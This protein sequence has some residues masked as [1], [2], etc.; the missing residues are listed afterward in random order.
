[1]RFLQPPETTD[2]KDERARS[3]KRSGKQVA[4]PV[5]FPGAPDLRNPAMGNSGAP[6]IRSAM[7]TMP[8]ERLTFAQLGLMGLKAAPKPRLAYSLAG[9]RSAKKELLPI[10]SRF[11]NFGNLSLDSDGNSG[12]GYAFVQNAANPSNGQ[13]ISRGDFTAL[14]MHYRLR[15]A[16]SVVAFSQTSVVGYSGEQMAND[17]AIGW[18]GSTELNELFARDRYAF[19]NLSVTI[20]DLGGESGEGDALRSIELAGAV[21]SGVYDMKGNKRQ[22]II[23]LSNLSAVE[24]VIDF[25]PIGGMPLVVDPAAEDQ[26]N[27]TIGPGAHR[28]LTFTKSGKQ[29]SL[30]GDSFIGLDN[31]RNGVGTGAADPP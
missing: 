8:I 27:A 21:W 18:A 30:S 14:V 7:F 20:G 4:M 16:D 26:D 28:L 10:I 25:P 5:L 9:R 15:G 13:L 2:Y 17:I 1:V 12:N 24:K 23:L 11:N 3:R 29:W 22:L 31:N 6:N 19:A